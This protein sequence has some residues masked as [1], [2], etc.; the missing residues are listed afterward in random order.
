MQHAP[1][2]VL[3]VGAGL[4]GLVA[5]C[6]L[7]RQGIDTVVLE[8]A[9]RIGGRAMARTTALGSRIDLGGQW[10]GADHHRMAA[11]AAEL[12][13][14]RYPMPDGALP[15]LIRGGRVLA[16][17]SPRLLPAG[18]ALLAVEVLARTG[19]T[20]RWNSTPL[21][22]WLRR[23]PGSTARQLLEVLALVSWTADLDRYSVHAMA[24]MIR[25][26]GGLRTILATTDGAQDSLLVE[27]V[28]TVVELLAAQL[29]P[30]IRTGHRV[31]AIDRD[32]EGVT[33]RTASQ[34][35]RGAKAIV[36]LPPPLA[37]AIV[38]DPPLPTPRADLERDT[39][40]GSVH[41]AIAVY[42]RPFWRDRRGSERTGDLL[43]LDTPLR[44]VFD[45]TPPGGPGHLCTLTAGAQA[46]ALDELDPDARRRR[47]LGPLVPHL[48]PEVLE[49]RDWHE[50]SW[51][52]DE[53]VGG[54]YIAL[55]EPGTTAGIPLV[56][57]HPSGHVHWAGSETASEHPGYLEGAIEA[58]ERAAREVVASI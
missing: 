49:P 6:E 22:S 17:L 4:S 45:T 19:G 11:L 40:M 21:D 23:V 51:H 14:H 52:L 28:G 12:G 18:R 36:T 57:H 29:G 30:R 7:H 3:V 24:R 34:E 54:G 37:G 8:A 25:C 13:L 43:V 46:R 55:P 50:K 48:G 15:R 5:A 31:V 56:S 2:T 20:G 1:P 32:R 38:H 42:D 47:L 41:K 9:D 10:L 44:A 26:Q 16:P 35:F 33:V 53:Y 27:G 39:Y 58:G